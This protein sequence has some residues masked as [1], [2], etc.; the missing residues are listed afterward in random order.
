[1]QALFALKQAETS[2][3]YQAHEYFKE[4]FAPDLNSMEVQDHPQLQANID[5]AT[6][7]FNDCH[8]AERA[9]IPDT[10]ET[11]KKAVLNALATYHNRNKKDQKF[12][13]NQM[14]DYAEKLGQNYVLILQYLV[15]VDNFIDEKNDMRKTRIGAN[16]DTVFLNK[17]KTNKVIT[18]IEA[19]HELT[20]RKVRFGSAWERDIIKSSWNEF[21]D[22]DL[23]FLAY[24]N[25]ANPSFED[26][27]NMV[28]HIMKECVF[29]NQWVQEYLENLNMFWADD[30]SILK[31]LV[32]RTIK[33]IEEET[34]K[35]TLLDISSNWEEDKDFFINLY[36]QTVE[37]EKTLEAFVEARL[38]NWDHE[39]I[40]NTDKI[41]LNMALCEMIHFPS[42]PTKVTINEY[43]EICKDYSTPK[44]KQFV[45][46]ILDKL[47]TDLVANG[48]IR[49]SGRGL[50]DNKS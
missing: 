33:S 42:I 48:T 3:Y 10:N 14:V 13:C 37:H 7:I 28:L 4:L 49:K 32:T 26:D 8:L 11:I 38:Q 5:E 1:M 43:I 17:L 46:G 40:A 36:E 41:I 12:Y 27:K 16:P 25:N 34:T 35:L 30:K 18:L 23:T 39:R 20:M 47:S 44:S 31:S 6:K 9:I 22:K 19:D 45:N 29:K 15:E 24:L 50:L 21:A 2:N